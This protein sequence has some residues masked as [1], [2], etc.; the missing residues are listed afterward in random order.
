[1]KTLMDYLEFNQQFIQI[2]MQVKVYIHLKDGYS[3]D[4]F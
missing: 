3:K 2:M 4:P 1:M